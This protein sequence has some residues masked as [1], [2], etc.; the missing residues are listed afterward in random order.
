MTASADHTAQVWEAQSGRAVA[1]LEGH[2]GPVWSASFSPNGQW[3][4]TASD[5]LQN[6]AGVGGAERARGGDAGRTYG[7][8]DERGILAEW[9]VDR[10]GEGDNKTARVWE[11]QSGRAVATLEGHGS[12]VIGPPVRSLLSATFS[13]DG[14][15]IVTAG[16]DTTARLW[17]AETGRAVATLEGHTQGV[18]SAAFSPDG[19]W[20]VTASYDKTARL[21]EAQSGRA[22]ATLKGHTNVVPNSIISSWSAPRSRQTGSGS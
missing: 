13:P 8:S 5:G 14:R 2:G 7:R 9:T 21:W 20:I 6:R 18:E 15:R 12:P 10:D 3:I 19:Q 1:T 17:E 4:V 22:V 11:A 16:A